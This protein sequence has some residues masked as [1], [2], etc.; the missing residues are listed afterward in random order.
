LA[1]N[2]KRGSLGNFG[3]KVKRFNNNQN[4]E[5]PGPGQYNLN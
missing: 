1:S 3:S 5:T 4:K 2:L